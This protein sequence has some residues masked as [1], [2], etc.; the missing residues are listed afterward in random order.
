M[1]RSRSATRDPV[2]RTHW[3]TFLLLLTLLTSCQKTPQDDRPARIDT[4]RGDHQSAVP[5]SL[6]RDPLVVR[7]LGQR[8][9]DFFGRKGPRQPM[10]RIPVVFE[11]EGIPE[12]DRVAATTDDILPPF[13]T[14]IDDQPGRPPSERYRLEVT[15]DDSGLASVRIRLGTANGDWRIQASVRSES[16]R[17]SLKEHFRVVSGV[18]KLTDRIE[19]GVGKDVDLEMRLV[20]LDPDG[21][22]VPLEDRLVFFRVVGQP[23]GDGEK[24]SL[25]NRKDVTGKDGVRRDTDLTLGDDPG[26]YQVLAE[27]EPKQGEKPIRGILFTIKAIDWLT[28]SL[29]VLAG[30]VLFLVGVR[31]LATGFLIVLSPHVRLVTGRLS[32]N[33]LLGYVGGLLA[34]AAFQSASTVSSHLV[35]FANGGL[36]NARGALALLLGASL[37]A[38]ILPQALSLDLDFLVAPLLSAGLLFLILPRG[39]ATS[40]WAGVFLGAGLVLASWSTLGAALDLLALSDRFKSEILP[41]QVTFLGGYGSM[42]L[43][44]FEYLLIGLLFG[45]VLRTSNLMVIVCILLAVRGVI[46]PLTT[47]P[48]IVG[49]NLGSGLN[50]V[51]RATVKA[52]EARRVGTLFFL[53]NAGG[54][55]VFTLLS[56]IPLRESSVLLWILEWATPGPLFHP[57]AENLEYHVAMAHTLFNLV[58]GL[59]VFA[60]SR[61]YWRRSDRTPSTRSGS[62]DLKPHRLDH[63][64]IPVPSLALRQA[65]EETVYLK[66]LCQKNVAEA[67]DSFRYGNR[68]LAEQVV[69]RGEIIADVHSETSVYLVLVGENQLSR[70]D[71]SELESLQTALGGFSRLAE[72]AETL[73]ELTAR[74]VEEQ[75]DGID[76]I[77]RDLGEVYDLIMAQFD[78]IETLLRRGGGRDEDSAMKTVE[79]LAKFRSRFEIQWRQRVEQ[80]GSAPTDGAAVHLQAT[81]YQSAFDVLFQAASHLAHIAERMRILAPR[82]T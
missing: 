75:I 36:L 69:R 22:L 23:S 11:V 3:P 53:L 45:L 21:K 8:S 81:V 48:L 60:V 67:F 39:S 32:T 34:G 59:T 78:N 73:R 38:T 71:A 42:L 57:L 74:R 79:R 47:I 58:G 7:V 40:H 63:N 25:K 46:L 18:E 9:R 16:R 20:K 10:R 52:R 37:G 50:T 29:E 26:I 14:L 28:L 33:P 24:A 82:R 68:D 54:A 76:E 61:W 65:V 51:A 30:A 62:D 43:S 15:T 17:K 27:V 41:A 31:V 6:L 2:G 12:A 5:G 1:K 44:F 70:G 66:K 72:C 49:A 56:L 64:L 13:P 80:A 55:M 77:D 19:T 35:S 4:V